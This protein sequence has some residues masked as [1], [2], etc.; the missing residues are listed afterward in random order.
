MW[1]GDFG[2]PDCTEAHSHKDVAISNRVDFWLLVFSQLF[3]PS[4]PS[5]RKVA[6]G[7]EIGGKHRKN[8]K[9][10]LENNVG[11]SGH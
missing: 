11:N 1:A 2:W 7:G 6:D 10:M 5:M 4:T 9:I 8:G 3:D